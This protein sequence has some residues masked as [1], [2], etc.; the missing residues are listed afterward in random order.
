M[1]DYTVLGVHSPQ[2]TYLMLQLR[3]ILTDLSLEPTIQLSFVFITRALTHERISTLDSGINNGHVY[4]T[5]AMTC[6]GIYCESLICCIRACLEL[7][8]GSSAVYQKIP[9][10]DGQS[11]TIGVLVTRQH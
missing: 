4:G 1:T 7:N 3:F 11:L 8:R 10:I 5:T 2:Y 6:Y 9:T